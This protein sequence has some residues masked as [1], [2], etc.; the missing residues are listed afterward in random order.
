MMRHP[1]TVLGLGDGGAHVGMICDG[2]FP[3]SMLTH[4]TRDRTRGD[5]LSLA[6]AVRAQTWDTARAYGLHDRG[7]LRPGLKADLNLIDHARLRLHPPVM[8]HDLPAGGK[9]LMQK[10]D[11]YVATL[12]SGV[13]IQRDGQPTGA[14]PGRLVRGTCGIEA[15]QA[16]GSATSV[17]PGDRTRGGSA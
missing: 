9:R 10:A 17:Q 15:G 4:W 3:T 6:E 14:M 16:A 8:A 13:V 2:S 1:H 5:Q 7:L 12:V 11:G